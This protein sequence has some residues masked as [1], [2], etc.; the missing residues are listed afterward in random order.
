MASINVE[1]CFP[2]QCN[3]V[4]TLFPTGIG[5]KASQA[6]SRTWFLGCPTPAKAT[7]CSWAKSYGCCAAASLQT[8]GSPPCLTTH[9]T[10]A[11]YKT[12]TMVLPPIFSDGYFLSLD[13]CRLLPK[14]QNQ[15]LGLLVNAQQLRFVVPAAKINKLQTANGRVPIAAAQ[16]SKAAGEPGRHRGVHWRRWWR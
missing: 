9:S 12:Q 7:P 5:T 2:H 3:E 10:Q 13:K 16:L 8:S 11:K 6:A 14:Q 1:T 4:E 15:S